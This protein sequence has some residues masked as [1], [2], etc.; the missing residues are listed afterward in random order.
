[1]PSFEIRCNTERILLV[2]AADEDAAWQIAE[3]TDFSDWDSA[4][5]PY[6]IESLDRSADSIG[7]TAPEVNQPVRQKAMAKTTLTM[8]VEYDDR[9]TDPDS[10]ATAADHLLKAVLS[11]SGILDEY[12]DPRFGE[13]FVVD[14]GTT[15]LHVRRRWVLY[16]FETDSLLTTQAYDNYQDALDDAAQADDVLVLPLVCQGVRA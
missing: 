8:D 11:T 13:F 3:R 10:L 6:S 2:E 14:S 1:M 16:S 9:V 12:A 4:D 15:N 7:P 5:S